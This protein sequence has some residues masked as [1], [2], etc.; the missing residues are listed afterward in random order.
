MMNMRGA[1][2]LMKMAVIGWEETAKRNAEEV[3]LQ[4]SGLSKKEKEEYWIVSQYFDMLWN[5]YED[6]REDINYLLERLQKYLEMGNSPIEGYNNMK[7][8]ETEFN[9]FEFLDELEDL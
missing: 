2:I 6:D 3:A 9:Y 4:Q 7:Y 8:E 5:E 1:P